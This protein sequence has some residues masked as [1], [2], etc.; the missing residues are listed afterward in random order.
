MHCVPN[1]MLDVDGSRPGFP[2]YPFR[3]SLYWILKKFFLQVLL[4]SLA[5]LNSVS[6]L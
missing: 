5:R 4:Q 3:I 1:G 6:F 2:V